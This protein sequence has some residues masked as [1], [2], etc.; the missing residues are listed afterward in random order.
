MA[1]IVYLATNRINGKRYVGATGRGLSAR[2]RQ[3]EVAPNSKREACP[4]FHA[5]IRKYG[6][7]AFEWT[8]LICCKTFGEALREE[9]RLIS[10]IKPEYN[11]TLGGE[12]TNGIIFSAE[13][14]AKIAAARR[15]MKFSEEHRRNLSLSHTGAKQT[16]EAIE[17]RAAGH[18][19]KPLSQ[20]H[21]ESIRK[22]LS[23]RKR[24]PE[25][26]AKMLASRAKRYAAREGAHG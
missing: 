5:A 11:L 18:R 8:V 16:T 13:R 12:G 7:D 10:K 6:P 17:A 2:R 3:H 1:A 23:G 20:S 22:T 9:V 4:Y 24:P 19:G 21:R 26:I 25:V 15:G 14:R